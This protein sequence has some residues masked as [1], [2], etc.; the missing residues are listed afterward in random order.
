MVSGLAILYKDLHGDCSRLHLSSRD[1]TVSPNSYLLNWSRIL[2]DFEIWRLI[3]P[4]VFF[5][6]F[7]SNTAVQ[8]G[9]A[10][11]GI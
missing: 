4:F 1:W 7:Q 11:S 6:M 2:L 9:D 8:Y 10:V 3:T 5:R